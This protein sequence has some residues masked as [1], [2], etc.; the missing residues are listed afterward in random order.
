MHAKKGYLLHGPPGTGKTSLVHVI[1]SESLMD[2][3]LLNLAS[4][5][6]NDDQLKFLLQS[7]PSKSVILLEDIDAAWQQNTR[8]QLTKSGILNALDGF[9]SYNGSILIMTS[10]HP[11]LLEERLKRPGRI[12]LQIDIDVPQEIDIRQMVRDLF[13]NW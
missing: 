5:F 11:E 2:I 3:Y 10:N 1:A 9:G 13:P 12:D 6:M 7:I 8:N 4:P